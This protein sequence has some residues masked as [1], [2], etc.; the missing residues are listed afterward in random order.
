MNSLEPHMVSVPEVLSAAFEKFSKSPAVEFEGT[1]QTRSELALRSDRLASWLVRHKTSTGSLVGIYM[2]R[3]I[4]M[5]VALLGVLKAGA[6]YVPLDPFSPDARNA[7]ILAETQLP[8]LLTLTHQRHAVPECNAEV[9][10]VDSLEPLLEAEPTTALPRVDPEALAYV[11]FTSGSTGKPKGVEIQ[12]RAVVN[13]LYD[14][15]QRLEMGEADRLL[16]VTTLAFDIAVLELLLP[17]VCG[18]TVVLATR[19][20]AMDGARL[21]DM[22]EAGR[23]TAIQATPYT[24]RRLLDAGF[25]AR[26]GFK[27]FCGGEAW[28][29]ALASALMATD[30]RLWNM[31]GPTETTVW[32]AATEIE[33]SATEISIGPPIANTRFY[34][35]D[36]GR[37][38]VA[39]GETGELWIAG[40][41]LARGYWQQPTLTAERFVADCQVP[42]E[43]MYRTGDQVRQ[44]ADGRFVFLGRDDHQIKYRGF[45]IE[46]GEIET[47]MLGKEETDS[48]AQ[49]AGFYISE[50]G[51]QPEQVRRHL[52][53]I[54]PAYMIPQLLRQLKQ[55]PMTPNGKTDR[56]ALLQPGW[57][58][59]EPLDAGD[60][61][62]VVAVTTAETMTAI[63]QELFPQ[64]T[65]TPEADF[66]DLGGDSLLVLQLQAMVERRLHFTLTLADV[67]RA[68]S[69]SA[70]TAWV[71]QLQRPSGQEA[72]V[73]ALNSRL[74][75]LR[76]GGSGQ[77]I[78]LMPQILLFEPLS[79][80]VGTTQPV[81]AM[82]L[83]EADVT[84]ELATADF[85]R[86][87]ARYCE[88]IREVQPHGPYFLG[89]WCMWGLVAYEAARQL[90]KDGEQVA[91][92]LV[93]DA[94]APG[95][96]RR[97]TLPRRLSIYFVHKIYRMYWLLSR[98]WRSDSQQR[99]LDVARRIQNAWVAV[100]DTLPGQERSRSSVQKTL[101]R[102]ANDYTGGPLGAP[103]ILIKGDHRPE[104]PLIEDDLGWG[105]MA[106]HPVDVTTV[107]GNHS[108]IFGAEGARIIA[109]RVRALIDLK[110]P[111][112]TKQG[113]GAEMLNQA[114][115]ARGIR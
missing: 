22:M 93:I 83:L 58:M 4:V 16:A 79:D 78:F 101:S 18:G 37:Q 51:L 61:A 71:E 106:G 62:T 109:S 52:Q 108:E 105:V 92:V 69:L 1:V 64:E 7:Q 110:T 17:L 6:A 49:L 13:L 30:G 59:P 40:I 91:Y 56:S 54:L 95:Y 74:V 32:S 66:F 96:W 103:V 21:K 24:F 99:R 46:L 67:Y 115:E 44:L 29:P 23:V 63:W 2:D 86:L 60:V 102:A 41:G 48:E 73:T 75:P 28:P 84:P 27:M 89:G 107:E 11:I 34:V 12:H 9:W 82:E 36:N 14:M 5:L 111:K 57:L 68:S 10:C 50:A 76:T 26:P 97:H 39:P 45:S 94:T 8:L 20:D 88:T 47:A 3:S 15:Q 55:F 19:K 80:E 98:L 43:R 100:R 87:A 90:E 38:P 42:G 31:Y 72:P 85:E 81:Y 53:Q 114:P 25:Q 113:R 112:F 70:L 77:P 33:K 65:I 104:G 35:L